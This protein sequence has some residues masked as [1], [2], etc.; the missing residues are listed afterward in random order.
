MNEGIGRGR[1]GTYGIAAGMQS[2]DQKI[3]VFLM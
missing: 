3:G 2:T 1:S